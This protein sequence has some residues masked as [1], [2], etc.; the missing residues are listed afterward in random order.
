MFGKVILLIII[1]LNFFSCRKEDLS[2]I[3][4]RNEMRNFVIEISNY[5]KSKRDNFLIIPQNGQELITNTGD[6]LGEVYNNYLANIDGTAREDLFYGYNGDDSPTPIQI[7]QE[8]IGLLNI[9]KRNLVVPMVIDYC[10]TQSKIDD[11]YQ[12]NQSFGFISFAADDRNLRKIPDYPTNPIN[13]NTNNIN[14][15]A[16]VRNFLY[17]INFEKFNSK[18]QLIDSLK[19]TNYDLIIIDL[20][21]NE[22]QFYSNEILQLKQKKNGARRLVICYMSIGEAESYR[23]YWHKEWEKNKPQWLEDENPSWPGNFKV[24]YW[25]KEWKQIIFGN[26]N[27]YLDKILATG[28]D[29]V[30]LDIIDAFDYFEQKYH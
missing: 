14:S 15:L 5:A 8:W 9:C 10:F 24:R 1:L 6:S 3:D 22:Q 4:F 12:K 17:L 7:T 25:Y 11:S 26:S 21:F 20:F 2:S 27:A 13:E 23:Y 29:G 30:Y 19:K 18:Q 16:E 28:F